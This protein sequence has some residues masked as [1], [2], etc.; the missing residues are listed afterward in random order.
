MDLLSRLD[1]FLFP[2]VR[3]FSQFLLHCL[4]LSHF[5]YT[6]NE[7]AVEDMDDDERKIAAS[8]NPNT[9]DG[10]DDDNDEDAF[11]YATTE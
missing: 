3:V 9:L 1:A 7:T 4:F 5:H 8:C 11:S 10:N 6:S 2:V